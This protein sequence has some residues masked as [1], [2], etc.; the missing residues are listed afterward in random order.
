MEI[1][2]AGRNGSLTTIIVSGDNDQAREII[3]SVTSYTVYDVDGG[4]KVSASKSDI[5]KIERLI[6]AANVKPVAAQVA[7][8]SN[9]TRY[10]T[11]LENA[12]MRKLNH[13]TAWTCSARDVDVKGVSPEFEGEQICYVYA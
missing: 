8:K 1:K 12:Q 3:K 2:Y 13:G 10:I 9:G 6:E 5:A 7:A 11:T 4:V